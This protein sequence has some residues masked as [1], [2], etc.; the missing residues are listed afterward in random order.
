MTGGCWQG[1]DWQL[2]EAGV[3]C[4]WVG[5]HMLH[6]LVSTLQLVTKVGVGVSY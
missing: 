5:T 1:S 3:L 4:G 6:S 2:L